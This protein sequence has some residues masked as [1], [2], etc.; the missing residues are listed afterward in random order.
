M[1]RC[2]DEKIGLARGEL[3]RKRDQQS[4]LVKQIEI[5][6]CSIEELNDSHTDAEHGRKIMFKQIDD[7]LQAISLKIKDLNIEDKEKVLREVAKDLELSDSL[8][9]KIFMLKEFDVST[10][11]LDFV[12][13]RIEVCQ[14]AVT[15]SPGSATPRRQA[16]R[17]PASR[18][19]SSTTA[20]NRQMSIE[21]VTGFIGHR[22]ARYLIYG[23]LLLLISVL[24]GGRA[25]PIAVTCFVF[26]ALVST[27]GVLLKY[28]LDLGRSDVM[29]IS[30]LCRKVYSVEHK[31]LLSLSLGT[32]FFLSGM[33]VVVTLVQPN[34]YDRLSLFASLSLSLPGIF[35]TVNWELDDSEKLSKSGAS[36]EL[37]TLLHKTPSSVHFTYNGVALDVIHPYMSKLLHFLGIFS[38]CLISLFVFSVRPHYFFHQISVVNGV[39]GFVFGISMLLASRGEKLGLL[40]LILEGLI[41]FVTLLQHAIYL[42]QFCLRV[43]VI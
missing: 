22:A 25:Y 35:P 18:G 14:N 8:R 38:Y 31:L 42:Y 23:Y 32:S 34:F 5:F 7:R 28:L 9:Q 41:L 39:L 33:Y 27:G 6:A 29:T 16:K 11:E 15:E 20:E 30:S 1:A 4:G 12:M 17:L 36:N 43:S 13:E 10:P 37:A 19:K 3:E 2:L 24:F 26:I 21:S 40:G